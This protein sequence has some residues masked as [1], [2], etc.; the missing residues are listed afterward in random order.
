M[1]RNGGS[2][3]DTRYE[4]PEDLLNPPSSQFAVSADGP[5]GRGAAEHS[6]VISMV[7][8]SPYIQNETTDDLAGSA[9]IPR[10]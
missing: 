10:D 7:L 8:V 4:P 6:S 9:V 2:S 1:A 3:A 5:A